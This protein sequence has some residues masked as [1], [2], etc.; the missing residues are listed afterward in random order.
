LRNFD[1]SDS[2]GALSSSKISEYLTDIQDIDDAGYF[3]QGAV[4]GQG[5]LTAKKPYTHT[6]FILGFIPPNAAPSDRT[7]E[8]V[9]ISQIQG[10]KQIVGKRIKISLDK[11]YVHDYPGL[12]QHSILCEFS[13]KNQVAGETEELRFAVRFNAGDKASASLSGV[14]IFMGVTVGSD[15]ISFEGR[16]INVSNTLDE[17]V[18]ATLE[19]P[20]FKNGLALIN[21]AQ[22]ALKPFSTLAAA[23]VKSTLA[24]KKNA[25]IHNFNLGLDFAA[26]ATSARLRHGSYVVIQSDDSSGWNW[27]DFEWSR[28]AMSLQAKSGS[29]RLVDF[30]YMIFGVSEF[31]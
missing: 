11:F 25:Q 15:G 24:R 22:P 23:A 19:S 6:G 12:G 29:A 31:S 21:A 5:F 13:G 17:V 28:D 18:L 7:S 10:D 30:N 1:S 2:L 4:S 3:S 16:T 26:G 8:I 27:D 9:G 14:P 20:A